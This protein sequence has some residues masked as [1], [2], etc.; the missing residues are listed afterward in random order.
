MVLG[1]IILNV[2]FSLR[3]SEPAVF[4]LLDLSGRHVVSD[5]VGDLGERRRVVSSPE[6]ARIASGIYWL[7]LREGAQFRV[8]TSV[9]VR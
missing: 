4:D 1:F 7:R 8:V 6:A 2:A 9:V 3:K 5:E